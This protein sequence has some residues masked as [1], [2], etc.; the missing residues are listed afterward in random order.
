M[1]TTWMSCGAGRSN[2][3]RP[4]LGS[5]S[6]ITDCRKKYV[7]SSTDDGDGEEKLV[8]SDRGVLPMKVQINFVGMDRFTGHLRWETDC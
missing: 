3:K 8:E 1:P 4:T 2:S 6:S 5:A 7:F